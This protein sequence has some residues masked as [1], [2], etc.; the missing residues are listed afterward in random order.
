MWLRVFHL[1]RARVLIL[2]TFTDNQEYRKTATHAAKNPKTNEPP[3][4][5]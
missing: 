1:Y 2:L 3:Q 5:F 4:I